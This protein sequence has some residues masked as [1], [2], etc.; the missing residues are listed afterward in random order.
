MQEE[1]GHREYRHDHGGHGS[2][3][4]GPPLDEGRPPGGETGGPLAQ[5]ALLGQ[6]RALTPAQG[7]HADERE[8]RGQQRHGGPDGQHH[9]EGRGDRHAVEEAEPQDQHAEQRDAD[10]GSGEH[11]GAARRRD[12]VPRRVVHG[13]SAPQP[14]A[15]P[16]DDEEGVVDPDAQTDEHAEH[17]R[18][19]GD[20]HDVAEQHGA[21]VGRADGDES[22]GDGQQA[23]R[24]RTEGEEE[25]DR[26]DGHPHGLAQMEGGRSGRDGGAAELDLEP[27]PRG[28]LRGVGDRPC[29]PGRDV[30][31]PVVEGHRGVGGAS[32]G[33]DLPRGRRSVRAGDVADPGQRAD[34]VQRPGHRPLDAPVADAGV[35]GVP[36]DGGGVTAEVLEPRL[37]EL[38]GAARLGARH[39]VVVGVRRPREPRGRGHASEGDQP[40]ED[41]GE[42][43]PEAPACDG[44]QRTSSWGS[45]TG[46]GYAG[47]SHEVT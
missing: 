26:G 45:W 27:L 1:G 19:V 46:G 23:G 4:P 13:Q 39:L 17:R 20:G 14:S 6:P 41:C 30:T 29:L 3:Q 37:Q 16:G 35:R 40:E 32:V 42:A 38:T 5:R 25:D 7:A 47:T 28:L 10:G 34:R 8:Q 21:R 15:V 36:D 9:R 33:A 22:G 11:D 2:Q 31:R 24:E 43:V 12:G 18:E 44:G